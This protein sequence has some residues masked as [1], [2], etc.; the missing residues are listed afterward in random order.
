MSFSE[1]LALSVTGITWLLLILGVGHPPLWLW[2]FAPL[3]FGYF[4]SRALR[5]AGRRKS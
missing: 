3:A 4:L 5:A 2:L 1:R